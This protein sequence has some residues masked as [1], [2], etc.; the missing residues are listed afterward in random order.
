MPPIPAAPA[1][2]LTEGS[3][4]DRIRIALGEDPRVC[5]FRNNVGQCVQDGR[6]VRYGT[7]GV[8]GSDLLG[9]VTMPDG[10]GRFCAMEVKSAT[11]RPS[12][13]QI[14]FLDAVRRRGGFAAIVRSVEDARA[15]VERCCAGA[16]E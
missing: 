11:G 1:K 13:E 7:G 4:Q 5:M 9:I 12:P 15:A 2:R 14:A 16:S 8:G 10:V 3:I 6:V